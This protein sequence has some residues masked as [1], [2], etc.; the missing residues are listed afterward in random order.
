[1]DTHTQ[2]QREGRRLI[3]GTGHGQ[4]HLL[5]W[6]VP[7]YIAPAYLGTV[8]IVLEESGAFL[9]THVCSS[10]PRSSSC[11]HSITHCTP[12][13]RWHSRKQTFDGLPGLGPFPSP[14]S[15]P[16]SWSTVPRLDDIPP[17]T[18][19]FQGCRRQLLHAERGHKPASSA[20][21]H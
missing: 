10:V 16:L 21:K 18:H 11:P 8:V 14:S 20:N 6:R 9:T 3:L 13:P 5:N 4:C 12:L 1:M 17:W 7:V 19:Q 15:I 2:R